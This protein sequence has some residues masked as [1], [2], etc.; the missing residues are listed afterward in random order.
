MTT[1]WGKIG[2]NGQKKTKT[3]ASPEAAQNEANKL[4]TEKTGKGY[5][6]KSRTDSVE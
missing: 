1:H 3:F 5:I 2:T 4:I 6:E